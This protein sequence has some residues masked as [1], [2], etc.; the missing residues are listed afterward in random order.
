VRAA[1]APA[2]A[3][4]RAAAPLLSLDEYLRQRSGG[5]R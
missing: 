1:P 3:T 4:R 5:A 2:Q